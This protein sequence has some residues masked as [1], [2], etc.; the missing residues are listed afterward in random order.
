MWYMKKHLPVHTPVLAYFPSGQ[1][2]I[3][4]KSDCK[5]HSNLLFYC[6]TQFISDISKIPHTWTPVRLW[7]R[8]VN[9]RCTWNYRT[10]SCYTSVLITAQW[11]YLPLWHWYNSLRITYIRYRVSEKTKQSITSTTTASTICGSDCLYS[12]VYIFP[13]STYRNSFYLYTCLHLGLWEKCIWCK[14][15]QQHYTLHSL[16]PHRNTL[17]YKLK[18]F[19]YKQGVGTQTDCTINSRY[20]VTKNL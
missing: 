10:T 17:K 3:T 4:Q 12:V 16:P 1:V 7:T 20:H 19:Q 11:R 14:F 6:A 2:S 5:Y 8:C 9:I 18:I 13:W 15:H